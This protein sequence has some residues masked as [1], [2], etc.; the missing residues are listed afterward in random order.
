MKQHAI[1]QNKIETSQRQAYNCLQGRGISST[2]IEYRW[3]SRQP[4]D[5]WRMPGGPTNLTKVTS[6]KV[7]DVDREL[8]A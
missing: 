3:R 7:K 4:Q 2:L 6:R 5:R 8:G 1:Q